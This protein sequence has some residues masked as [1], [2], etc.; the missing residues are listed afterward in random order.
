MQQPLKAAAMTKASKTI[1]ESLARLRDVQ[2]HLQSGDELAA[3]GAV[4]GVAER[5]QYVET[6]LMVL[7]DV[8]A[9]ANQSSIE[10]QD[11]KGERSG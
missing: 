6:L 5:V 1:E 7:R 4:A 3:L 9:L 8:Q 2:Q 11:E 10:F